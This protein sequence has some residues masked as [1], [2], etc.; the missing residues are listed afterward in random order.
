MI[1]EGHESDTCTVTSGVPQ[2]T[3]LGPLCFLIY[4]NDIGEKLS[5]QTNLKL[6]ADDS[7][8]YREIK[9]VEDANTLQ[10]DLEALTQWS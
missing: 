8:I 1:I 7:L 5:T 9:S 6:F 4:I 2:G 10:Q 3:V